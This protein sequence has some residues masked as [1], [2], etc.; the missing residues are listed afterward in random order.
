MLIEISHVVT[1]ASYSASSDGGNGEWLKLLPLLSG[2][3]YFMYMYTKYRNK[4]KRHHHERETAAEVVNLVASDEKF[5][6]ITGTSSTRV[7]GEN[8][9]AVKAARN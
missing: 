8:S 3:A 5:H 1:E 9:K 4:D 6:R 7:Q 2:P